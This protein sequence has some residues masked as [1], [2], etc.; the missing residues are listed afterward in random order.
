MS[1]SNRS[2]ACALALL[3]ALALDNAPAQA[4][5]PYSGST[6]TV[7][8]TTDGRPQDIPATLLKPDGDGPFP[9]IVIMHDCSGLGPRSGGAPGRWAHLLAAQGYVVILPDSFLPRGYPQGVCTV[10]FGTPTETVN[11]LPRARDAY[12][13]LAY[14]RALAFVD[15]K[16]VG[17]MGGSH[18]GSTTLAA[19]FEP[20][21]EASPLA[22]EKRDGFAA[23]IALYPGCALRMGGWNVVRAFGNHGPVTQYAGAYKPIA[24][25]LI[26]IG[27]KDDWTPA[28]DCKALADAAQEAGYPVTIKIYPGAYHA[29]DSANPPR[30]IDDRRNANKQEGH[31]AT[32]GGDPV[33]WADAIKQA[34]AFF[35]RYLKGE[36]AGQP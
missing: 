33:A 22:N 13:A 24:P 29:F 15:G 1:V 28:A 6:V 20:I 5:T 3:S 35:G 19:M 23:A 4:D 27:E 12:A 17:I 25:L 26:L 34:N 14:L 36:G 32:T 30:Y 11:P 10:P 18:G 9:A 2:S 31:G 8:S 7:A 16:H 21:N